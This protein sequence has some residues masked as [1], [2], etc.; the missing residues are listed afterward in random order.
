MSR[1]LF[2]YH[3]F[4]AKIHSGATTILFTGIH[5]LIGTFVERVIKLNYMKSAFYL[6]ETSLIISFKIASDTAPVKYANPQ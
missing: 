6:T 1:M 4:E 3:L 2:S 5:I